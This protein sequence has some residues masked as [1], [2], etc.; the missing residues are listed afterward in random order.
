M[1]KVKYGAIVRRRGKRVVII[2][3]VL[4]SRRSIRGA[5]RTSS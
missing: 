5:T 4:N 1:K 3:T 2:Q